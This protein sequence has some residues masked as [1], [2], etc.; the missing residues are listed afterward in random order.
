M[1]YVQRL[2][3]LALGTATRARVAI[4]WPNGRASPDAKRDQ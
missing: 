3:S 4:A 2:R 1:L